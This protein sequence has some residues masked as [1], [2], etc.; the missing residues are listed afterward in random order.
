[1]KHYTVAEL[2]VTARGWAREYV[3]NVT[4]MVERHGGRYLARTNAF[5]K[6]EGERE[7]PGVMLL[8]EWPDA[9]AAKRF[10]ES[11][12][13]RPYRERRLAGSAGEFLLVAG[14]D[15]NGVARIDG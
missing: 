6:L 9:D 11:E 7:A 5:E 13:Y 14:E 1:M 12:E 2:S 10:Y 15:V 8:I 3:E 4:P